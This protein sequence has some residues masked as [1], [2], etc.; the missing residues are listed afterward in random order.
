MKYYLAANFKTSY[1]TI[2][3]DGVVFSWKKI[4]LILNAADM[5]TSRERIV[6]TEE[7]IHWLWASVIDIDLRNISTKKFKQI[8]NTLD[9]LFI[10]WWNWF[11]LK[12][13]LDESDLWDTLLKHDYPNLI[14]IWSSAWA[15]IMWWDMW[16]VLFLD[17]WNESSK[18]TSI[19]W[20]AIVPYCIIPHR[21]REKYEHVFNETFMN[22]YS[23]TKAPLLLMHDSKVLVISHNWDHKII[24]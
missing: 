23:Y 15:V 18:S 14:Y 2:I 21:W 13:L 5:Y 10:N 19:E 16:W 1:Q 6:E 22:N 20:Y 8:L 11:Y 4:W 24:S 17:K 7:L 12:K 3:D 9:I